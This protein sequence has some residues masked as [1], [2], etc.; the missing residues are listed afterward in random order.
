MVQHPASAPSA[1][2]PQQ[3]QQHERR[4]QLEGARGLHGHVRVGGLCLKGDGAGGRPR[5]LHMAIAGGCGG[6]LWRAVVARSCGGQ[7]WRA[8]V[9]LDLWPLLLLPG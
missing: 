9:A 7:L 3:P 5:V 4:T 6:R 8:V 1:A 2:R